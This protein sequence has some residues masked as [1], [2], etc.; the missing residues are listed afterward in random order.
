[1]HDN[2]NMRPE[3]RKDP[4][5]NRWI[6]ISKVRSMR[7]NAWITTRHKSADLICPFCPGNESE[8]PPEVYAIRK[9]DTKP[10]KPGWSIRVISNKYPALIIEGEINPISNRLYEKMGGVGAHEVLIETSHHDLDLTSM[11]RKHVANIFWVI[12]ERF[13]D[14]S[15]DKRF[16]FIIAFKNHGKLAGASIDHPHFQIIAIPLIPKQVEEEL[17]GARQYYLK[18]SHCIFCDIIDQELMISSRLVTQTRHFIAIEP[19]AARSPYET[20][21]V[22]RSHQCRFQEISYELTSDLAD[23]VK[24]TLHAMNQSIGKP[25]FNLV[26][27]TSPLIKPDYP[28]YHWHLEIIPK[29]MNFAGFEIGT[30]YHINPIPPEEAAA[31]LREAVHQ[32]SF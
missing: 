8:T 25:A 12:R 13:L 16:Q 4:L 15:R 32:H 2:R 9:P 1:M 31:K 17:D 19:Y 21:I 3:I 29:L 10:N 28:E 11:S 6:I 27:H 18:N 22:P 26:L 23:I 14:L 20:W 5:S 7:P 24:I 30:G